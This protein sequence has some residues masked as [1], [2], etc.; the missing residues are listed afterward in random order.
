MVG[1]RID[2]ADRDQCT[3]SIYLTASKET[4]VIVRNVLHLTYCLSGHYG[5]VGF[6]I[7][8]ADR[9]QCTYSM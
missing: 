2:D 4:M 3:Y 1:F 7:D 8:N 6:R 9:D 5:V